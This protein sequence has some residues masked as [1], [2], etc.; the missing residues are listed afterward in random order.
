[1]VVSDRDTGAGYVAKIFSQVN[2]AIAGVFPAE[3]DGDI[4]SRIF[5]AALS[6]NRIRVAV[7]FFAYCRDDPLN[8]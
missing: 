2:A 7:K 3:I 8:R 4:A 5:L 1:M 6:Q